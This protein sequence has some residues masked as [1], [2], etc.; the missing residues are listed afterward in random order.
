MYFDYLLKQTEIWRDLSY[1][2]YF[3]FFS[4][5]FLNMG[6]RYIYN[7]H[8]ASCYLSLVV[9][10]KDCVINDLVYLFS[11]LTLYYLSF[12]TFHHVLQNIQM[13]KYIRSFFFLSFLSLQI[14]CRIKIVFKINSGIS[15]RTCSYVLPG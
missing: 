14:R 2:Y 7:S 1:S 12:Y 10:K 11:L 15:I 9:R 4:V 8:L 13:V 6:D 5:L 3:F